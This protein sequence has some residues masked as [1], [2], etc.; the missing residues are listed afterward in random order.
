M[1]QQLEIDDRPT[2]AELA[3]LIVTREGQSMTRGEL[4]PTSIRV[5]SWVMAKLDAMT[6]HSGKSRNQI[7]NLVIDAGL[8]AVW[9]HLPADLRAELE[10]LAADAMSTTRDEGQNI[11]GVV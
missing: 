10:F 8:E 11:S 4:V 6:T 5:P 3:A 1:N 9:S 2:R 7:F